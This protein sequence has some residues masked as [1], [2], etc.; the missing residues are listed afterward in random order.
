MSLTTVRRLNRQSF[1][2]LPLSQE[3]INGVHYLAR[4]NQKGLDI[5]Y[6]DRRPFLEPEY[7]TN[8]NEDDSTYAP[9]G[10]NSSDNKYEID[11]NQ[12]IHN[13]LNP[14]VPGQ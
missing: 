13:N 4:R 3:V 12:K 9:S 6:R 1:N 11:N 14:T 2:T 7:E 5:R 10:D 8:N